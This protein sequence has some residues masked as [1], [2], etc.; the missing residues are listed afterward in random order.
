VLPTAQEPS[1][2]YIT[3]SEFAALARLSRKSIDRL[4][5]RRP[6]GFPTEYEWGLSESKHRRQP[7]FRLDQVRAW[8]DSRAL[9]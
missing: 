2:G 6:D 5:K 3:V 9:W 1:D 8:L 7:R 4:R